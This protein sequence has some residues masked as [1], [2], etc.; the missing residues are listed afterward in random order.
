MCT[1]RSIAHWN[2]MA[3]TP[4]P[5]RRLFP[6]FVGGAYLVVVVVALVA[7]L[8]SLRTDDF[9]GLNNAWLLLLAMPWT[10]LWVFVGAVFLP[11][12]SNEA[13]AWILAGLASL[14]A[15]FVFLMAKRV[16]RPDSPDAAS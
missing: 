6:A 14:N 7:T 13:D 9:D 11:G 2:R 4:S 10:V 12:L 3:V 15:V 16:F 5:R 8:N 1:L